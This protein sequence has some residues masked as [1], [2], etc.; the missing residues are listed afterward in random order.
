MEIA[1]LV[2]F[3]LRCRSSAAASRRSKTC[4]ANSIP[5]GYRQPMD[6]R[7]FRYF[8][9]VVEE[10]HFGR[11]AARLHMSQP[12]L[13]RAIRQLE[14]ELGATLLDRTP[15]GVNPT[16]AG[17]VL[18]DEARAV[19]E[20]VDRLRTRVTAVAGAAGL[21][22]GTLADTA[23]QVGGLLVTLFRRRHPHVTVSVHET[24]LGDPT[25][26]LRT[27]LVDVALTRAPF[28]DT[29][30]STHPL[31]SDLVGVVVRE[32]DQLAHHEPV[33]VAGL[34]DRDWVRLPDGTDPVW[35]AYWTGGTDTGTE[36]LPVMRTIQECLQS[37]LWNGT[38]ALAPL[39]QP[40]P[41]GLVNVPV[42]D[43]PP[44]RLVVAWKKAGPNPLV[45]SFVDIAAN[46]RHS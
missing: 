38:S 37:V 27:G 36:G 28:D 3:G 15:K 25:A 1:F 32:D 42:T 2:G 34:G 20:Q 13:S 18:Y 19:L 5:C 16:P 22:V 10:R 30:I 9:A 24:D 29:G 23:D 21:R 11:A 33:A 26:G 44:S 46:A 14:T 39:N 41:G 35:S 40:L 43:R 31:R 6:L 4:S 8:V 45:R 7:S 12:P 17:T